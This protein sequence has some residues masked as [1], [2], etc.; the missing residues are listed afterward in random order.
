MAPRPRVTLLRI[1]ID[2]SWSSLAW[3][4]ALGVGSVVAALWW[5]A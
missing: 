4:L 2:A 1:E 5:R 3:G